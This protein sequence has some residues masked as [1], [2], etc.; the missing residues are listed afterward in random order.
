M[1][2]KVFFS[3]LALAVFVV[4]GGASSSLA[5]EPRGGPRP[6]V[7]SEDLF[8]APAQDTL[9]RN[10]SNPAVDV[11]K[12]KCKGKTEICAAV[13]SSTSG[14]DDNT[15]HVTALCVK[16]VK[17]S[18]KGEMEFLDESTDAD[19]LNDDDACVSNCTEAIVTVNC[20][21]NDF[22]DNSY[23]VHLEC[24]GKGFAKNFPQQTLDQD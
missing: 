13:H 3:I 11:W 23:H 10:A 19:N 16:P 14:F 6:E 12:V 15:F 4:G 20:E 1:K 17:D 7:A 8:I 24:V 2:A 22:C 9:N 21:L 18:E 5:D